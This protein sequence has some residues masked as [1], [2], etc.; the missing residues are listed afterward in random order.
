[1]AQV[2]INNEWYEIERAKNGN[3]YFEATKDHEFSEGFNHKWQNGLFD[4]QITVTGFG[5]VYEKK[6]SYNHFPAL[7][8]GEYQRVYVKLSRTRKVEVMA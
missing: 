5:E 1:M 7:S 2:E 3:D 8:L 6:D 4:F